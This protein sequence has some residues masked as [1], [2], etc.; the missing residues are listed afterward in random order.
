MPLATTWVDFEGIMLREISETEKE[1]HH[2]ISLIC[3]R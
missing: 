3:G 2:V 1:K